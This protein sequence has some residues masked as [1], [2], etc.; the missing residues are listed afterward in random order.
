MKWMMPMANVKQATHISIE[1]KKELPLGMKC[2][3]EAS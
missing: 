2:A 1:F 3:K